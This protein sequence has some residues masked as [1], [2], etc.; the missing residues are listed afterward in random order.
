MEK[1]KELEFYYAKRLRES[2]AAER[3]KLY[4]EAY[5]EVSKYASVRF[6]ENTPEARTAG[7]TKR[8]VQVFS[9]LVSKDADVLE[10]GCGRGYTCYKLAPFVNSMIGTDVS[11]TSLSEA[12]KIIR[13][14]NIKNVN[15]EQ[16][17]AFELTDHFKKNMFDVCISVDVVEHLH[18]ADA[19][20]H[21][22][23]V[24]D[25]LKPGGKYIMILPN[26]LS[27]PHDVTKDEFPDA[28]EPLG[29]HL[30]E[31]TYKELISI[32]KVIGFN[33]FS[34]LFRTR[35]SKKGSKPILLPA[36]LYNMVERLYQNLPDSYRSGL[37]K[38]L[39]SIRLI[40]YK[41]DK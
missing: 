40:A 37:L 34:A 10:I 27:G 22:K 20:E 3:K 41:P 39:L 29:F 21:Y 6:N 4:I 18:P 7:T 12:K 13:Q 28:K 2:S 9:H 26:R 11:E 16:V 32:M 24:F 38:K 17:S 33:K 30:N 36:R 31:S 14:H 35:Q 15:I 19:E 25:I 1:W 5:T 8:L 23:Q